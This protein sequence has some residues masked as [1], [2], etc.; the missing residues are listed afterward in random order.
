[1]SLGVSLSAPGIGT[2]LAYSFCG[3]FPV[4]KSSCSAV[5][6]PYIMEK[7]VASRPE[8]MAKAASLLGESA[9]EDQMDRV[10]PPVKTENASTADEAKMA[11]SLIRSYMKQLSIP[12]N[13][14]ELSLTLDKLVSV[15]DA[16]RD[17]EF[18]AFSP[19]TVASEDAYDLIKQAY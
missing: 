13:F 12:S 19:W 3:R 6:L 17:L 2:A 15:A 14:K 16:A 5:L 11:V 7:L 4:A 18:V 1:M 8:K 9:A 10:T